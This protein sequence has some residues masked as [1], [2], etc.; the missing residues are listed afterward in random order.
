MTPIVKMVP[1]K[2]ALPFFCFLVFWIPAKSGLPQTYFFF[3][4]ERTL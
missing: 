2:L 4:Y 1:L 3:K